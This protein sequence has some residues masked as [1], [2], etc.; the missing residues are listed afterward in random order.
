[1]TMTKP[2]SLLLS[3]SLPQSNAVD[4]DNDDLDNDDNDNDDLDNDDND[5]DDNDNDDNDHNDL[6]LSS[7]VIPSLKARLPCE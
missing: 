1:M 7:S 3:D 2:I 6:S 4:N 5:N